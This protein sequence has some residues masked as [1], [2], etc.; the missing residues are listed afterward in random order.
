MR[1]DL[2]RHLPSH[3][4]VKQEFKC[5]W[6]NC[7]FRGTTR[8]DN[9]LRHIKKF[10]LQV[11]EDSL[12]VDKRD[13]FL[14]L[15]VGSGKAREGEEILLAQLMEAAAVGDD[16]TVRSYLELNGNA[17][18]ND[19]TGKTMLHWAAQGGHASV[20][21]I[22]IE[23]G[24]NMTATADKKTA[25]LLAAEH[26]KDA[27][28]QLLAENGAKTEAEDHEGKTALIYAAGKGHAAIVSTLLGKGAEIEAK[29]PLGRTALKDAASGGHAAIVSTLLENGADIEAKDQRGK[30]A[31]DVARGPDTK[32][33][34]IEAGATPKDRRR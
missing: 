13:E 28:V 10:H 4:L 12:N 8:K 21:Q 34:L 23:H 31:L 24:V 27:V 17:N 16:A 2:N 3:G 20:V 25:L 22:L 14:R 11:E 33:I 6:P 30:T 32:R 5:A 18:L 26:G 1:L 29:D 9:L 15:S 7:R 19:R